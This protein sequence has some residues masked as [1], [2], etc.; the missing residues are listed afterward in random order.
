MVNMKDKNYFFALDIPLIITK[1]F[2]NKNDRLIQEYI[3]DR[4]K[5]CILYQSRPDCIRTPTSGHHLIKRRYLLSRWHPY[6]V[7]GLC[8]NCHKWAHDNEAESEKIIIENA[9]NRCIMSDDTQ[10]YK[11]K[12]RAKK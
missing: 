2:K 1:Q 7:F 8:V 11:L 5:L 12:E 4:D 3:T 9:V 6:N 10:F